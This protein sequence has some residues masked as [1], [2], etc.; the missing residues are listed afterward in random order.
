MVGRT[1]L[2]SDYEHKIIYGKYDK[3]VEEDFYFIKHKNKHKNVHPFHYKEN[4]HLGVEPK[5]KLYSESVFRC[6]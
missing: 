5:N 4:D 3:D 1:Y 2:K 6:P